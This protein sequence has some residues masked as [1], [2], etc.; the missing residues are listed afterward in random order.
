METLVKV[1]GV[2]FLAFFFIVLVA[3]LIALPIMWL[4]NWLIVPKLIYA[5]FGVYKLG[6]LKALGIGLLSGTL[7][8][9]VSTT[10]GKS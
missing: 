8:K 6:F 4:V 3:A 9:S 7:F 5:L 1:L 2:I 10:T